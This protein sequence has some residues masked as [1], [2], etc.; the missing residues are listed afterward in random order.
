MITFSQQTDP[1]SRGMLRTILPDLIL[2]GSKDTYRSFGL[3]KSHLN[4]TVGLQTLAISVPRTPKQFFSHPGSIGACCRIVFIS[5]KEASR[6]RKQIIPRPN[7]QTD[8]Q[9]ASNRQTWSP[10][11]WLVE[12]PQHALIFNAIQIAI[13][14]RYSYPTCDIIMWLLRQPWSV[15]LA[16]K[17]NKCLRTN[18]GSKTNVF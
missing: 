15:Y 17:Q 18:N 7:G 12:S 10:R 13:L 9:R 2:S 4:P 6:L 14:K 8:L 3:T 1:T 16:L 5:E 11:G